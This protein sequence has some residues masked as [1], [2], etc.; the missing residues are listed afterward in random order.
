MSLVKKLLSR[1]HKA[2]S[3]G[4]AEGDFHINWPGKSGKEYKYEIYP[5][6]ASFNPEPA[7]YIYA[8]QSE[9]G[10]WTPLYIAQTRD[11]RQRL[12][13]FEKQTLAIHN[14]ATHIHVHISNEGQ[15]ARCSEE[16]DLILC[17]QPVCN[18]RLES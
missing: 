11:L 9:D 6:D 8:K 3:A 18:D 1:R 4:S 7:N 2:E 15:A 17:W 13:G 16:R 10:S 5:I 12:E 14:G